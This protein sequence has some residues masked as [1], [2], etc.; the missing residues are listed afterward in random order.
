VG[1]NSSFA[2]ESV[3]GEAP[4]GLSRLAKLYGFRQQPQ[5]HELAAFHAGGP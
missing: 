5:P 3:W 1:L 2:D 4:E